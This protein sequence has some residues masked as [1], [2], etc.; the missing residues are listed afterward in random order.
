M[1]HTRYYHISTS[2]LSDAFQKQFLKGLE[3]YPLIFQT[4]VSPNSFKQNYKKYFDDQTDNSKS[5]N[6]TFTRYKS[7]QGD[8][9]PVN[10]ISDFTIF[11]SKNRLDQI[12]KDVGFKRQMIVYYSIAISVIAAIFIILTLIGLTNDFQ[13]E[14]NTVVYLSS[15]F[16]HG[17][18]YDFCKG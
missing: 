3:E 1:A 12:L 14:F 13:F 17:K 18:L 6:K 16:Y 5:P 9:R 4:Q 15:S 10:P 7:R 2:K 11:K 8:C